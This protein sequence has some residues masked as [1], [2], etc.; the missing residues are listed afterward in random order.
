MLLDELVWQGQEENMILILS[1][2]HMM[3]LTFS[4]CQMMAAG[5]G[6]AGEVAGMAATAS[7]HSQPMAPGDMQVECASHCITM[8]KSS[9][10]S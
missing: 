8:I 2:S 6:M 9:P 4:L 1:F 3:A 7:V 10:S 5:T